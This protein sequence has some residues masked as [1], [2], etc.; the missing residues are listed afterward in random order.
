MNFDWTYLA[1]LFSHMDFWT[2]S[3]TV[4]EL[5]LLT[6]GLGNILGMLLALAKQSS[7]DIFRK[8]AECYIWFFRSLPL[9]VL[10][11]FVYNVPQLFPSLSGALSNPFVAGL[12]SMVLSEAAYFAEIHRS[13][14]LAVHK[15]QTEAGRALGFRYSGIQWHIIFPQAFR[16]AIP[17]LANEFITIVKLT[18]LVSVISLAEILIVG[19]RL[20]TQNF[21]VLETLMGVAV[22]YVLIVSVFSYLIGLLEKRIDIQRRPTAHFVGQVSRTN[23]QDKKFPRQPPAANAKPILELNGIVKKYGERQVLHGV[24]LAVRPGEVVSIIGP[25]GSGKTTLI[26]TINGLESLD[27][28]EVILKG[29]EFLSANSTAERNSTLFIES[30][31]NIGMVFQG[32]NLFPHKTVLENI[33]LAPRYHQLANDQEIRDFALQLL[34]K[35]GL[36]EHANKY[37]HQ[38]SGGQQQRVA[39]ARALAMRPAIILFDEPTSA[40][41]PELVGEVLTVIK[42]LANEG[43][44]MIIVTHEMKFAFSISDRVVFME[45]GQIALEGAPVTLLSD[46]ANSRLE[47]FLDGISLSDLEQ[48]PL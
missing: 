42:N 9:L 38:L 12:V 3:L 28:G 26:R 19:E 24:S 21:K 37:P 31:R 30:I 36:L 5:S 32:F 20:Y 43:I 7:Y 29:R 39:I 4:V 35:V 15:G 46:K 45:Q 14:L 13:G 6:W 33:M 40:L 23:E 22:Y 25:S 10:L 34:D 41:D 48:K 1:S 8:P 18:S 17:S 2:A 27:G 44:T 47:K 16:V 11:I